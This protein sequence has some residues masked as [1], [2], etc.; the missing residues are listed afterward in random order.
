MSRLTSLEEVTGKG[1][2]AICTRC[3]QSLGNSVSDDALRTVVG[4]HHCTDSETDRCDR[5]QEPRTP[6]SL[7]DVF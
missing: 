6:L 1:Q 7:D 2:L 5:S 4:G 3:G